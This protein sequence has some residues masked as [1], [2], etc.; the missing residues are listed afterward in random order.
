MP[1]KNHWDGIFRDKGGDIIIATFAQDGPDHC[2]GLPVERF[3]P[4]K[5]SGG[6]R[7]SL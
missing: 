5:A 3:D 4:A 6:I 1:E 7:W 2:S